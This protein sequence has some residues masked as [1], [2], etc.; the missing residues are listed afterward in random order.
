MEVIGNAACVNIFWDKENSESVFKLSKR[1]RE[2]YF[3][4]SCKA[5]YI[6]GAIFAEKIRS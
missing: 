6:A 1:V 2:Q 3:R 4:N 5:A